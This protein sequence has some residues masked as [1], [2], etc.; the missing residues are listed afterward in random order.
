MSERNNMAIEIVN[1]RALDNECE[2]LAA[3]LARHTNGQGNGSHP[4]AIDKLEFRRESS[5]STSLHNVCEPILVIIVQGKK[6]ILLG[7][8]TYPYGVAQY[9]VVSVDLP[10]SAFVV[11][12]TPEQPYLAFKLKLDLRQLCDILAETR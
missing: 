1:H 10:M 4:T 7:E 11:E 2:K 9:L 3:L 6:T 8:E 12:A 5:A